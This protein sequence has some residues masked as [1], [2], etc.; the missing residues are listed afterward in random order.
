MDNVCEFVRGIIEDGMT[1]DIV[2]DG[3]ICYFRGFGVKILVSQE[4][5]EDIGF[6]YVT[7]YVKTLAMKRM[8]SEIKKG[9]F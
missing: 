6:D 9:Y 3:Y 7:N 2:G 8:I 5:R 1:Y 4:A